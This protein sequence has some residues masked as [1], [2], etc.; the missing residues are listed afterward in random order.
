MIDPVFTLYPSLLFTSAMAAVAARDVGHTE[1]ARCYVANS[2][3]CGSLGLC[4][5][6][7]L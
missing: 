4:R 2:V 7:G 5:W 1:L 6:L 3:I